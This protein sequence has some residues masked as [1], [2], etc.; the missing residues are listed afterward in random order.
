MTDINEFRLWNKDR[1]Q[2]YL[3]IIGLSTTGNE[4]ELITLTF[5]ALFFLHLARPARKM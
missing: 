3:L 4:E 2:E 5:D 1:N